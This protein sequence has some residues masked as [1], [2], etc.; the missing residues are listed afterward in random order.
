MQTNNDLTQLLTDHLEWLDHLSERVETLHTNT[1]A[2][3][4]VGHRKKYYD[5]KVSYSLVEIKIIL[6]INF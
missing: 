1:T 5:H 2:F 3:V 6:K 4:Q